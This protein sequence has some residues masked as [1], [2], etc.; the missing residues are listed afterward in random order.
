LNQSLL[1]EGVRNL[2]NTCCERKFVLDYTIFAT[3]VQSVYTAQVLFDRGFRKFIS[4][5]MYSYYFTILLWHRVYYLLYHRQSDQDMLK[6]MTRIHN[7]ELTK[8]DDI[9]VTCA[10]P[11]PL[12]NGKAHCAPRVTSA[13][14]GELR[15]V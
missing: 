3:I 4:E 7:I 2:V 14:P 1:L 9:N 15:Y 10:G 6:N 11:P 5:S 8:P 13:P 12:R